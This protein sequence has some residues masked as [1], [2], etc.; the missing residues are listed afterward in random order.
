MNGLSATPVSSHNG[1]QIDSSSTPSSNGVPQPTPPTS[2]G[3]LARREPEAPIAVLAAARKLPPTSI[4]IPTIGL[5]AHIVQT[6]TRYDEKGVLIWETAAFAVGHYAGTAN[7]GE[8]GNI[9]LS[10]HVSSRDEGAVFKRLPEIAV[11]DPIIL[12]TSE[13]RY[14]YRTVGKEVVL[15]SDTSAMR[16][17]PEPMLTLITCV[18]DGV[19]THRLIVRAK[20]VTSP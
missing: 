11:G 10:G 12:S 17:T 1:Q 20:P 5:D 8:V 15:P 16:Q 6:S 19:F 14:I 9:V 4:I 13:S 7:V 2:D 3:S 18:P